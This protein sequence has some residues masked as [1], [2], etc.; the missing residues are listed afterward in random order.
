M[1]TMTQEI[2]LLPGID[3]GRADAPTKDI[4]PNVKLIFGEQFLRQPGR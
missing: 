1:L 2:S 3:V 4:D